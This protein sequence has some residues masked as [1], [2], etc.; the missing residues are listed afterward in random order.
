ML[1]LGGQIFF[2]LLFVACAYMYK[3]QKKKEKK[4]NW[5]GMYI[6]RERSWAG[7]SLSLFHGVCLLFHRFLGF[8]L[9]GS[10]TFWDPVQYSDE[11][12]GALVA[13]HDALSRC[14][15]LCFRCF[16]HVPFSLFSTSVS[17][18]FLCVSRRSTFGM[19]HCISSR[20]RRGLT[21]Q[22]LLYG[23]E[24]EAVYVLIQ[25]TYGILDKRGFWVSRIQSTRR[26][27]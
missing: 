6:G 5:T 2:F 4:R 26:S 18:F 12:P 25:R 22:R 27:V 17:F 8:S 16:S 9:M 11:Q 1:L 14:G 21:I 23:L 13:M 3:G 19:E 7:W 24:E 20:W 10:L 15:Q